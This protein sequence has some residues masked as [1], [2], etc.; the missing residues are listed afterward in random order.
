MKKAYSIVALL[1]ALVM[2][3]SGMG[4]ACAEEGA[5]N[6]PKVYAVGDTMDDFTITLTDGTDVTLS[7][8]LK[9]HKAVLINIWATWC[10]PCR[11]EFP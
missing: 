6:A 7:E 8:L 3:L 5:S 10:G 1:L 9:T 4:V 11:E 2:A